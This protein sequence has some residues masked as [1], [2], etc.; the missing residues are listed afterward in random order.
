M[1]GEN[2]FAA[3]GSGWSL[4]AQDQVEDFQINLIT[5]ANEDN[6]LN[7]VADTPPFSAQPALTDNSIAAGAVQDWTNYDFLCFYL[8][9]N[10]SDI[11]SSQFSDNFKVQLWEY[12]VD[13]IPGNPPIV[14]HDEREIYEVSLSDYMN[15]NN[16]QPFTG[17]RHFRIPFSAFHKLAN[18]GD[19]WRYTLTASQEALDAMNGTL[20]KDHIRAII[21]RKDR[22]RN[23]ST[24]LP[25][26]PDQ[27]ITV[28]IDEIAVTG[29]TGAQVLRVN[30]PG[31][32]LPIPAGLP[33]P[34]QI[35]CDD[36]QDRGLC[37]AQLFPTPALDDPDQAA[38]Y[39]NQN[40]VKPATGGSSDPKRNVDVVVTVDDWQQPWAT[41]SADVGNGAV[42]SATDVSS[43]IVFVPQFQAPGTWVERGL[44][45]L[46]PQFLRR[47]E[48][49]RAHV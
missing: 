8:C 6:D 39:R 13:V 34:G 20:D 36:N 32:V 30:I 45:S 14:N 41:F 23:P 2:R 47:K 4:G 49:G 48:I 15:A 11:P 33:N 43:E 22:I 37:W 38:P 17:W 25:T 7:Y 12:W 21:F 26:E 3:F 5:V 19:S 29:D 40:R 46:G 27:R 10:A 35:R 28:A 1:V 16:I 44:P 9:V 31:Q 42:V 24:N 18:V